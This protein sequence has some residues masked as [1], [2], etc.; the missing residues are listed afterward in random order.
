MVTRKMPTS[1]VATL[2]I[3]SGRAT[4]RPVRQHHHRAKH[5]VSALLLAVFS[6]GAAGAQIP[7]S[8][9]ADD[10][11][12]CG[13]FDPTDTNLV[14]YRERNASGLYRWKLEDINRNHTE[15]ARQRMDA[16]EHSRRV[17]AD[18]DY[19][20]NRWPNHL[21]GLE[22][23][24]RYDLS[25]GQRYEYPPVY[26]YFAHAR[27][28]VPD[29]P[30][31]L[32]HQ[33]YYYWKKGDRQRAIASYQAALTLDRGSTDAHYSLGLLYLE[34]SDYDKA[35]EH[36]RAAYAAGYPL[37]GLQRKLEAA[38]HWPP[39]PVTQQAPLTPK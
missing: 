32:L 22:E 25:G 2:W 4:L 13:P 12:A 18:I 21:P 16:G 37:P 20:L 30:G 36:A 35:V 24:I 9:P 7:H 15:P 14:D 31:V 11:A 1:A 27:Q 3:S 34:T 10:S 8:P 17:M 23:L 28:F 6:I 33:G 29:D 38:G 26:C 19:L 39:P 5:C